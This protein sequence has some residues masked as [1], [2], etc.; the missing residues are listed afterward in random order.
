[1]AV[2]LARLQQAANRFHK[3]E[4]KL[5]LTNTAEARIERAAGAKSE[6]HSH[7]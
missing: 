5:P 2:N 7:A 1:M 4:S 6:V 3:Y